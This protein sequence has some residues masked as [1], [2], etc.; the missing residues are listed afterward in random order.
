MQKPTEANLV[1]LSKRELYAVSAMGGL[2][3]AINLTQMNLTYSQMSE[4]AQASVNMADE[5]IEALEKE[6]KKENG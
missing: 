1:N 5:L 6:D 3:N 4:I 2:L